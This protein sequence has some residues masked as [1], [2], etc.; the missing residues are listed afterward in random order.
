M[1]SGQRTGEDAWIAGLWVVLVVALLALVWIGYQLAG[2]IYAAGMAI[3]CDVLGLLRRERDDAQAKGSPV[4]LH[5]GH[6]AALGLEGLARHLRIYVPEYDSEA[7][8]GYEIVSVDTYDGPE[9]LAQD[10]ALGLWYASVGGGI[11]LTLARYLPI[12]RS[13]ADYVYFVDYMRV[14]RDLWPEAQSW[15]GWL[16]EFYQMRVS[17]KMAVRSMRHA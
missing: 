2:G 16:Y 6:S 17:P 7:L 9:D 1:N 15:R 13:E 4:Q 12:G 14:C 3:S 8:P 5:V 11:D 10:L